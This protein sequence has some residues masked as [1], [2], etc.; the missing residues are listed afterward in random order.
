MHEH[1]VSVSVQKAAKL[2]DLCNSV[3][4]C[5]G[6]NE[7]GVTA[8]MSMNKGFFAKCNTVTPFPVSKRVGEKNKIGNK[9]YIFTTIDVIKAQAL[10]CYTHHSAFQKPAYRQAFLLQNHVTTCACAVLHP[11][12]HMKE[13]RHDECFA[14]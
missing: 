13:A 12:I 7:C 14:I 5:N 11:E 1:N 4:P 9:Y 3:T 6:A 10:R 8:F 2:L